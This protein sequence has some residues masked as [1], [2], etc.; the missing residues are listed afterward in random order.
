MRLAHL[1]QVVR[2]HGRLTG[3]T[4]QS[5][6]MQTDLPP[7]PVVLVVLAAAQHLGA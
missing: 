2:L 5:L 1:P 4:L 7:L 6:A 3:G